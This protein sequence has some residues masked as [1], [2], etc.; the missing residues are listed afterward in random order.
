M[1]TSR[2]RGPALAAILLIALSASCVRREESAPLQVRMVIS[3]NF[4]DAGFYD[5]AMSGLERASAEFGIK[6]SYATCDENFYRYEPALLEA[7]LNAQVVI[8]L[9]YQFFDIVQNIAKAKSGTQFIY[10][11]GAIDDIPNLTCVEFREE[12]GSYLAGTLAALVTSSSMPHA[13]GQKRIGF[14][15]GM[16][17]P[18]IRR[19]QDGYSHGALDADGEVQVESAFVGSF[20]D[21]AEG[22]RLAT[23]LYE[24]GADVV[25]AAAGKAGLGALEAARRYGR[26]AI[27]V[28]TDQRPL[29]PE[30]ILG[31]MVKDSGQAIYS[32]LSQFVKGSALGG[33]RK[34]GLSD[35][36]VGLHWGNEPYLVP[37]ELRE[38]VEIA[39]MSVV[40]GKNTAER[41]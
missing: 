7:A 41:P 23:G 22:Y 32:L 21:V 36:A 4:G 26:Y 39:A 38:R 15:G 16:D 13:N 5:G 40:S 37:G 31:S 1:S 34:Y 10:I 28:G 12:E 8:V 25:F 17:I 19:F 14:L 9:G 18:V 6:T 2:L 29:D 11:D 30:H 3:G 27:G 20:D 24:R 33:V 35:R